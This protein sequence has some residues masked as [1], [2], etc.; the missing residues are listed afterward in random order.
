MP[1]T[2][3]LPKINERRVTEASTARRGGA[4]LLPRR[5]VR[6]IT[7]MLTP[8][9]LMRSAL[10]NPLRALWNLR[11]LHPALTL[12]EQNT[13]GLLCQPGDL[14]IIAVRPN[15]PGEADD[16]IDANATER[17]SELWNRLPQE[18]GGLD[19]LMETLILE[20]LYK[21]MAV[22]EVVP[23]KR[24]EGIAAVYP[25][26][27]L[28]VQ[29][30]HDAETGGL[31]PYQRQTRG[32]VPLSTDRTF[33]REMNGG[34]G[35]PYGIA[36]RASA[37]SEIMEELGLI[38]DMRAAFRQIAWPRLL[39]AVDYTALRD[40]ARDVL[41][42]PT[43]DEQNAWVDKTVSDFFTRFSQ[44]AADDALLSDVNAKIETIEG[45]KGLDNSEG[46]LTRLE[47]RMVQSIGTRPF[48]LG[49]NDS[50]TEAQAREQFKLECLVLERIRSAAASILVR[51]A[52]LHLRLLGVNATAK[53]VYEPIRTTDAL[54]EAQTAATE[55]S[56]AG[57]RAAMGIS[58]M[59]TVAQDVSGSGLADEAQAAKWLEANTAPKAVGGAAGSG[60]SMVDAITAAK[61]RRA[62]RRGATQDADT[63]EQNAETGGAA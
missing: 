51:V 31:L 20:L 53:A 18:T 52:T 12:A 42:L 28:T 48:L 34:V 8:E 43:E 63:Q 56:T 38:R 57:R 15:G 5:D 30:G 17:L 19:G 22:V 36:V 11:G 32:M 55:L 4:G 40:Y 3:P 45:G 24:M 39:A 58:S 54:I 44:M 41:M 7:L 62:Q 23:G 27:A 47:R 10:S 46:I 21:G 16:E 49:L 33:W 13:L 29:F 26:D 37:F 14:D 9:G 25:V 35:N 2:L 61:E 1:K 60:G 6:D 50:T 59:E